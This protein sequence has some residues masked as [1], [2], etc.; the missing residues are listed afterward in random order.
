MKSPAPQTSFMGAQS[1]AGPS[2]QA[3]VRVKEQTGGQAIGTYIDKIHAETVQILTSTPGVAV[4]VP[5]SPS[6]AEQLPP[7]TPPDQK[8]AEGSLEGHLAMEAP[9]TVAILRVE[10]FNNTFLV[11]GL[12]RKF[13]LQERVL[14]ELP[15]SVWQAQEGQARS[16]DNPY[17]ALWALMSR[18]SLK[19]KFISTWIINLLDAYEDGISVVI[20]EHGMEYEVPW[21]LFRIY[22]YTSSTTES[23]G[24]QV[25]L[26]AMIPVLRW[27][28]MA[29]QSYERVQAKLP[30]AFEHIDCGQEITAY[31][32][33]EG[34]GTDNKGEQQRFSS[35]PP[36]VRWYY[37]MGEFST[38]LYELYNLQHWRGM[39]YIE[40]YPHQ[41]SDFMEAA[42][43]S[44]HRAS[45]RVKLSV[46]SEFFGQIGSRQGSKVIA[47]LNPMCDEVERVE[48]FFAPVSTRKPLHDIFAHDYV[49]C[50]IS[51]LSGVCRDI[52]VRFRENLF[53]RVLSGAGGS[54]TLVEV[55]REIR[56]D[57]AARLVGRALM[58]M[59]DDQTLREFTITF[60]YVYYGNIFASLSLQST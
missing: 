23:D 14:T 3:E 7:V 44:Q 11:K 41:L 28:Q 50:Y 33:Q 32:H 40:G 16:G 18:F 47:I 19:N 53:N 56:R 39:I 17:R 25:F 22:G 37:E 8:N 36:S 13:E 45:Q 38:H 5:R 49:L 1:I 20:Q 10:P 29:E 48:Q 4:P 6:E 21:E 31:L 58:E 30:K 9:E 51:S 27:N 34:E 57:I 46:L 12:H 35:P 2:I 54:Q 43:G 59:P 15:W 55:L 42:I 26:G 24:R 60:L 52:A